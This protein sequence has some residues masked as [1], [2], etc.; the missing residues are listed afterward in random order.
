MKQGRSAL[1]LTEVGDNRRWKRR[2]VFPGLAL[3]LVV[4]ALIVAKISAGRNGSMH[5]LR[6]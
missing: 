4:V 6:C 1:R 3:G 5:R 2:G